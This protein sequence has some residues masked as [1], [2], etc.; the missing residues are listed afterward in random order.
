[1]ID[2][3]IATGFDDSKRLGRRQVSGL[4]DKLLRSADFQHFA[5]R[6]KDLSV[7][8]QYLDAFRCILEMLDVIVGVEGREPDNAAIAALHARHPVD[9]IGIDPAG[10]GIQ[11]NPTKHLQAGDML[12]REPGAV[13][14]GR[15]VI[16]E[17]KRFQP[18]ISIEDRDLFIVQSAPE[19]VGRCMD[20]RVHKAG[21][22]VYRRWRW[23]KDAD[24]REQLARVDNGRHAGS[25]DD[26]HPG[27]EERAP[28]RV[29]AQVQ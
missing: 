19:N 14:G 24:L 6:G 15:H 4:D 9:R 2:A 26:R 16:F 8:A 12:A 3:G 10:R 1:M 11:R 23:R 7:C 28:T 13:R 17:H 5:H 18:A 27:F 20:M 25:A 22:R 21:N 29:G